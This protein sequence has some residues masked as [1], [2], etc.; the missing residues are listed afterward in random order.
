MNKNT[1]LRIA[2]E[3]IDT[4]SN[5]DVYQFHTENLIE[6]VDKISDIA[7]KLYKF[8]TLLDELTESF[9][10]AE[11]DLTLLDYILAD[12]PELADKLKQLL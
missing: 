3:C 5:Q 2:N 4:T 8:N 6:F 1:I 9:P 12:S 10:N 11:S 7:V